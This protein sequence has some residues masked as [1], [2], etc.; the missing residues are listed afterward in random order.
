[1]NALYSLNNGGKLIIKLYLLY[2]FEKIFDECI[3]KLDDFERV[4]KFR[5]SMF[6]TLK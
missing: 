4:H 6:L 5:K 1:M 2:Y 3:Y